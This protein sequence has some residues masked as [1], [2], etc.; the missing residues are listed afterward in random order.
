MKQIKRNVFAMKLKSTLLAA[1]LFLAPTLSH[2]ELIE[3][4]VYTKG[5]ALATLDTNTGIEW[6]DLTETQLLRESGTTEEAIA[7]VI[8]KNPGWRLPT[9]AEVTTL[10]LGYFPMAVSGESVVLKVV[11]VPENNEIYTQFRDSFGQS[12]TYDGHYRMGLYSDGENYQSA[13]VST[14]SGGQVALDRLYIRNGNEKVYNALF[15]VSDGGTTISSKENPEINT[16]GY[17]L[18]DTNDV[19]APFFGIASLAMLGLFLRQK[20]QQ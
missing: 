14:W 16:P 10:I 11:Y 8:A 1:S 3:T 18:I 9:Q 6:L 2:A 15:L 17:S 7:T 5:D 20:S 12:S 19:P 4:D 13:G